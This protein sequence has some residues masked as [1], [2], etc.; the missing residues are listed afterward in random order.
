MTKILAFSSSRA[1]NGGYLETAIPLIKQFLGNNSLQIAFIPFASVDSHEDYI[2]AVKSALKI[3]PHSINLITH[4]NAKAII[5]QSDV[6]MVGGGN[7]FKLLHDLYNTEVL[8]LIRNMILAGTPYIGWSAGSNI[9]SP[10]IS[11]TNDMPVIEPQSFKSLGI[12]PFQINPHYHNQVAQ[13][14]NGETRD[15]RLSEFIKINPGAHVVGLPEGTA[16]HLEGVRL[17]LYGP[18]DAVLFYAEQDKVIRSLIK[19]GDVS[20]LLDR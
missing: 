17:T 12:F 14:F 7:S 2:N 6:I 10:A 20:F 8:E 5:A 15:Q 9:L 4:K 11:T 18:V 19:P 3:L 16:L 13:G 1:G